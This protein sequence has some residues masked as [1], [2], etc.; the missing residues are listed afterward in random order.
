MLAEADRKLAGAK[1][2]LQA[3]S[4]GASGQDPSKLF[5]HY[6]RDNNGVLVSPLHNHS[7]I[8]ED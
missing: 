2:K 8:Q 3:M 1:R 7:W 5:A 4:Y 6:D